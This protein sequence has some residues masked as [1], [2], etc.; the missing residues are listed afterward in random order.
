MI[1]DWSMYESRR[2]E[3]NIMAKGKVFNWKIWLKKFGVNVVVIL[4]AGLASVYGDNTYYLALAPM[5][6]AAQNF[7]KHKY[8]LSL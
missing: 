5:L 6:K 3:V 1:P 4:I 7:L 2:L 8:G